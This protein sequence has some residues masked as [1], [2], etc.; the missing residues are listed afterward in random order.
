MTAMGKHRLTNIPC[1]RD[2]GPVSVVWARGAAEAE[3]D[4]NGAPPV[5][6]A[7]RACYVE[8]CR[9]VVP[10]LAI[11]AIINVVGCTEAG[12]RVWGSIGKAEAG[13][14]SGHPARN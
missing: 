5:T 11:A 8:G 2:L 14:I 9:P 10:P 7:T 1:L 4:I 12:L 3:K 13:S 6:R